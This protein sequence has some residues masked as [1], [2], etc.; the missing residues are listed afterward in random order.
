MSVSLHN[1]GR[2][3]VETGN[4]P[5]TGRAY[6]D[7]AS[8]SLEPVEGEGGSLAGHLD[9]SF[10]EDVDGV[11]WIYEG[12]GGNSPGPD[13]GE[14]LEVAIPLWPGLDAPRSTTPFTDNA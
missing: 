13:L 11:L 10:V 6:L 14:F 4:S 9:E 5:A 8:F 7:P 3:L 2:D 12:V 1:E